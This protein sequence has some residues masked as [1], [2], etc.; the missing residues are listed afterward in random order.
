MS[1]QQLLLLLGAV[2]FAFIGPTLVGVIRQVDGLGE[3]FLWNVICLIVPPLLFAVW[4][5]AFGLPG[6]WRKRQP[7]LLAHL[8]PPRGRGHVSPEYREPGE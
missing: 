6:N 8:Q 2:F 1:D 4:W 5:M 7:Q 3:L